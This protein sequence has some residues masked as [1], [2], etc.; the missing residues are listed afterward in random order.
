MNSVKRSILVLAGLSALAASGQAT[1]QFSGLQSWEVET[2]VVGSGEVHI[3]DPTLS[4]GFSGFG[5]SYSSSFG[6]K[7]NALGILSVDVDQVS[8]IVVQGTLNLTVTVNGTTAFTQ[9]ISDNIISDPGAIGVGFSPSEKDGT[10]L[11]LAANTI[12]NVTYSATYTGTDPVNSGAYINDFY[13][14]FH[15][16]PPPVP[17]PASLATI[18]VGIVGL[19]A[20][21]RK[22][23][24]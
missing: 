17:E 14:G 11:N 15:E 3:S 2:P 10:P 6:V 23:S 1:I 9:T 12:Y 13:V 16:T 5:G 4:S 19:V 22:G 7:S 21:R 24:K 20:R 18:G 8:G